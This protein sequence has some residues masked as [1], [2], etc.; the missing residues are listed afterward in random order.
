MSRNKKEE[1]KNF[2]ERYKTVQAMALIRYYQLML[3]GKE[4]MHASSE[5]A[6]A[7]YNKKGIWSYK[8][9]SVRGWAEQYLK[10]GIAKDIFS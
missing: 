5:V 3:E 8:A 7:L 10:T 1:K 9:R 2:V 4:K 6:H